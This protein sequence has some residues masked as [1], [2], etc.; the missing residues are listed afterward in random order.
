MSAA[1]FFPVQ[2]QKTIAP[3][4]V[5]GNTE[6]IIQD[7]LKEQDTD[8][9]GLKDWEESLWLTDIKVKDTDGD[10]TSDGQEVAAGRNPAVKAPNDIIKDTEPAK[11]STASSTPWTTTDKISREL[12]A[13]YMS[14]R[15]SG[16]ALTPEIEAQLIESVLENHNFAVTPEYTYEFASFRISKDNPELLRRYGNNIGTIMKTNAVKSVDSKGRSVHEIL[17]IE[18][19]LKSGNEAELEQLDPI[20]T[21]YENIVKALLKVEVPQSASQTHLSLINNFNLSIQA[22]KSFRGM[23]NDPVAGMNGLVTYKE[24]STGVIKALKDLK[25]YFKNMQIQYGDSEPGY[26]ITTGLNI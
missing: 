22:D 24:G 20:I 11:G 16:K 4:T 21:S 25:T 7:K 26:I 10:G 1:F 13:K 2:T 8:E 3:E 5:S 9:D 19:A 12:F 18:R 23:F 17:I 14:L 6:V 15:Q